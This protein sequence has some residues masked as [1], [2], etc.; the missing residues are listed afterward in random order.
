MIETNK[1]T[2]AIM[3]ICIFRL[4]NFR[5][6][7]KNFDQINSMS[8]NALPKNKQFIEPIRKILYGRLA[9]PNDLF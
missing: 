4:L 6:G 7:G 1:L 2:R 8:E 9:T 3:R 5:T